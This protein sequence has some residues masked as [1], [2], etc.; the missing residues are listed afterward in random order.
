MA[1]ST[2]D[3]RQELSDFARTI[4]AAALAAT[5]LPSDSPL[6]YDNLN[7]DPPDDGSV[8]ARLTIQNLNGD[9]AALGKGMTLFRREGLVTIQIFVPIGSSTFVADQLSDSIAEAFED[10]A[11][12]GNIWFRNTTMREVGPDG[13][14]HQVNIV[15]QYVYDRTA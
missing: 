10:A 13:T 15:T 8:W 2:D 3:L 11:A 5:S 1:Q 6:T 7:F 9:R 14:F 12:V 4:W